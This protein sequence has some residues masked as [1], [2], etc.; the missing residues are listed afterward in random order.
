MLT[1]S[2]TAK[3]ASLEKNTVSEALS[4]SDPSYAIDRIPSAEQALNQA[5]ASALEDSGID[6]GSPVQAVTT[7]TVAELLDSW[8][9]IEDENAFSKNTVKES[10]AGD[11]KSFTVFKK[12]PRELKNKI[13]LL[14]SMEEGHGREIYAIEVR[15]LGVVKIKGSQFYR[16]TPAT[17][18]AAT[19]EVL[20]AS[21]PRVLATCKGAYDAVMNVG[22]YKPML[23]IR[24]HHRAYYINPAID[25]I[26]L[27]SN[28]PFANELPCG[29]L[30]EYL[31]KPSDMSMIRH[32]ALPLCFVMDDFAWSILLLKPLVNLESLHLI[33]TT[34]HPITDPFNLELSFE[35]CELP[36]IRTTRDG[37][38]V[39]GSR[40]E[41]RPLYKGATGFE[42]MEL[43]SEGVKHA[44]DQ[45]RLYEVWQQLS[46]LFG[47]VPTLPKIT[48]YNSYTNKVAKKV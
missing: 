47:W 39:S 6:L 26:H 17:G 32:A 25:R 7:K 18:K 44:L 37:K 20:G 16:P 4:D 15:E 46:S 36:Y 35:K 11:L 27:G 5:A 9:V 48:L 19:I 40:T 10:E 41:A 43:V 24:G 21:I 31:V 12:L 14:A 23:Q 13:W 33:N 34:R 22:T 28:L 30:G 3:L 45:V 2:M 29:T 42:A 8:H 38:K 1:R